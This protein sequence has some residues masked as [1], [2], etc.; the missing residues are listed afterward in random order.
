[1][2]GYRMTMPQEFQL[3]AWEFSARRFPDW[4]ATLFCAPLVLAGFCGRQ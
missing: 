3:A 1:M 4:R 2:T